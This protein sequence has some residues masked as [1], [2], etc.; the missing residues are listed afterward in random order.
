HRDQPVL[1][2][3]GLEWLAIGREAPTVEPRRERRQV[4]HIA[5]L[6]A[7]HDTVTFRNALR[8]VLAARR[9]LAA[10]GAARAAGRRVVLAHLGLGR[11]IAITGRGA[12]EE[13][14]L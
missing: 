12:G 14:A 5:S 7:T 9:R 11:A 13:A 3:A 4:P 1:A 10:T 6:S 8:S 2:V